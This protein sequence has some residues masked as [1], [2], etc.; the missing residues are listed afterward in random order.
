MFFRPMRRLH[1][2]TGTHVASVTLQP[3]IAGGEVNGDGRPDRI[4]AG[5]PRYHTDTPPLPRM[6]QTTHDTG[7]NQ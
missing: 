7:G 6:H 2:T 3:R 1:C 5:T 4:F